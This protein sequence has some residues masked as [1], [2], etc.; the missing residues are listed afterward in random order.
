M[1]LI[2]RLA[3]VAYVGEKVI[4]RASS[5]AGIPYEM[6]GKPDFRPLV[7]RG[8]NTLGAR[9]MKNRGVRITLLT[10]AIYAALC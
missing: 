8:Y 9:V 1:S 10:G 4:T 3:G 7:G 2:D 5:K 6:F